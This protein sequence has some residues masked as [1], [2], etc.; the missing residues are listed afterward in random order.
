[1]EQ[2]LPFDRILNFLLHEPVDV[3]DI[4]IRLQLNPGKHLELHEDIDVHSSGGEN[5]DQSI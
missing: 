5:L 4:V 3:I 1:M 2:F